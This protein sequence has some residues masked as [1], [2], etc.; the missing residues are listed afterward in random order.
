MEFLRDLITP[1]PCPPDKKTEVEKLLQELYQI[2]KN[3]DFLSERPG[4][5]FNGQARHV[6]ARAIGKRLSEIGGLTLML[7]AHRKVKRK[8][9]ANLSSHLEYAWIDVGE[10]KHY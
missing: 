1:M 9:G 5:P 4:P 6:R 3:D 10:W 7:Y 2:G 8:L